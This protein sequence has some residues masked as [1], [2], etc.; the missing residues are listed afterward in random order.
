MRMP[1]FST[2]PSQS[3]TA[4]FA[5]AVKADRGRNCNQLPSSPCFNKQFCLLTYLLAYLP[6]PLV[7]EPEGAVPL[8]VE[9]PLVEPELVEAEPVAPAP[10]EPAAAGV[11]LVVSFSPVGLIRPL[12]FSEVLPAPSLVFASGAPLA[13]DLPDVDAPLDEPLALFLFLVLA[14]VLVVSFSPVGLI[15][16]AR[17]SLVLPAPS[18][19]FASG[20][21]L[22]P[23]ALLPAADCRE[24]VDESPEVAA[25][26]AVD[27]PAEVELPDEASGLAVELVVSFSPVALILPARFPDVLPAPSFVFASAPADGR[28]VALLSLADD[29]AKAEVAP[30]IIASVATP[31]IRLKIFDFDISILLFMTHRKFKELQSRA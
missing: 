7:V 12:R 21:S 20:P 29:C 18:L 16:P 19:V 15:L 1:E 23:E 4:K 26:P 17:F 28:E 10:D 24:E 2:A 13:L 30:N 22:A 3:R 5:K 31:S 9:S 25:P 27:L 11:P 8:L 14:L 6:P